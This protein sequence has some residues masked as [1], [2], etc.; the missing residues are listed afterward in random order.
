MRR[1]RKRGS[2]WSSG[3]QMGGRDEDSSAP[4]KPFFCD[5][6]SKGYSRVN[7]YDAHLSS[8]DHSHKKRLADMKAMQRPNPTLRRERERKQEGITIKPISLGDAAAGAAGGKKKGGFRSAFG[9]VDDSGSAGK[10]G[11]AV[12]GG[13]GFKKVFVSLEGV[14]KVGGGGG[15]SSKTE[16]EGKGVGGERGGKGE[17]A[18]EREDGKA[19][20]VYESDSD[21]DEGYG[22]GM[23]ARY[24][25][26]HPTPA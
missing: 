13:G 17:K 6:C 5:L 10:G 3:S 16:K 9:S 12:G 23:L 25:P 21:E 14:G 11:V 18:R 15:E 19:G 8:Y 2:R 22:E 1:R 7:E 26:A 24:D 20:T 4:K